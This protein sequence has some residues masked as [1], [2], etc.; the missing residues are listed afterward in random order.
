M[1][2][3]IESNRREGGNTPREKVLSSFFVHSYEKGAS[4]FPLTTYT[5]DIPRITS[6]ELATR[7]Y[8]LYVQIYNMTSGHLYYETFAGSSVALNISNVDLPL[9]R[10][11]ARRAFD[12]LLSFLYERP[13]KHW[14]ALSSSHHTR[15]L[16]QDT[17]R[18]IRITIVAFDRHDLSPRIV[19]HEEESYREESVPSLRYPGGRHRTEVRN[20]WTEVIREELN[21]RPVKHVFTRRE[22]GFYFQSGSFGLLIETKVDCKQMAA[23]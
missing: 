18:N 6:N 20:D 10:E 2:R 22:V 3:K 9:Q 4:R 5:G 11:H 21:S 15:I 16:L 1:D 19:L 12:A 23:I 13:S 14:F 17:F 8:L 7:D